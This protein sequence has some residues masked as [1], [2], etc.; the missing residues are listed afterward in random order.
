M[1]PWHILG[2][3]LITEQLLWVDRGILYVT[4]TKSLTFSRGPRGCHGSFEAWSSSA[5]T[6]VLLPRVLDLKRQIG[7]RR[8]KKR[9]AAAVVLT[10]PGINQYPPG[11]SKWPFYPLVG[12]HLTFERVT[13]S[14]S[15]KGHDRRIARQVVRSIIFFIFTPNVWGKWFNLT[16]IVMFEMGWFKTTN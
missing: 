6:C 12:G 11:D 1:V 15:Q 7:R 10:G 3:R 2:D 16:N 5:G 8:I 4:T 14:P 9:P 13:F